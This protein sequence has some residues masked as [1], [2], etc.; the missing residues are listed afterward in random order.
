[1]TPYILGGLMFTAAIALVE[2]VWVVRHRREHIEVSP[3]KVERCERCRVVHLNDYCPV[4]AIRWCP[5]CDTNRIATTKFECS[6]CKSRQL[7]PYT[8]RG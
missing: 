2:L 5:N 3:D 8:V 6:V 1:M 4:A 7:A